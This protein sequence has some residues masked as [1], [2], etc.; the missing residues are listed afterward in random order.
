MG[1]RRPNVPKKKVY[2]YALEIPYGSLHKCYLHRFIRAA[3]RDVYILRS[4]AKRIWADDIEPGEIPTKGWKETD[5]CKEMHEY[6]Q[7]GVKVVKKTKQ[8]EMDGIMQAA[9]VL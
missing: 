9:E 2:Y 8:Q 1:K 5:D 7:C 6:V 4:R 3:D